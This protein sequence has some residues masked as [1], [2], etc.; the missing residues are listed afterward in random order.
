[1]AKSMGVDFANYGQFNSSLK[2]KTSSAASKQ[3]LICATT[4]C[5]LPSSDKA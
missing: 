5:F 2:I 1:M 3:I 4:M